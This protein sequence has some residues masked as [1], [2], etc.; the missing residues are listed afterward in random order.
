MERTKKA[1]VVIEEDN[2][3][4]YKKVGGGS[5]RILGKII[6]PGERFKADPADIPPAFRDL[7]LPLE[8]V[9]EKQPVKLDITKSAYKLQQKGTGAWFDVVDANGKVINEKGLKKEIAEKLIIDLSR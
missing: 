6:K 3:I 5:M 4:M 8:E 7:C 9:K 1:E 2:R